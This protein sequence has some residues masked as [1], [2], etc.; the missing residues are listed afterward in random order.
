MREKIRSFIAEKKLFLSGLAMIVALVGVFVLYL[1]NKS[2]PLPE[3]WY[4]YFAEHI[5]SGSSVYKD[6]EYLFTPLYISFISFFV[7]IFGGNIL[8]SRLLG[9]IMFLAIAVIIYLI[10]TRNFSVGASVFGKIGRAHV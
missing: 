1:S 5:N 7:K 8:A 9:V 4:A 6:F 10:M 3:G 2:M